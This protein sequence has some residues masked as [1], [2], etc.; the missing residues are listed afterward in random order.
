MSEFLSVGL[1][2]L[3]LR[4]GTAVCA[5]A[6]DALARQGPLN[7]RKGWTR[8][9]SKGFAPCDAARCIRAAPG[10]CRPCWNRWSRAI[11]ESSKTG[12]VVA[13]RADRECE[14]IKFIHQAI[15]PAA[16]GQERAMF[17]CHGMRALY[18]IVHNGVRF[19]SGDRKLGIVPVPV[20]CNTRAR[21]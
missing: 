14:R 2:N 3:M 16:I 21:S 12:G 11:K 1:R 5:V 10:A 8:S 6:A 4:T 20:F 9:S 19:S 7:G 18:D 17:T 15:V 13:T